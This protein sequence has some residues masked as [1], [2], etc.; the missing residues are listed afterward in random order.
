MTRTIYRKCKF[1]GDVHDV[2]DWPDNHREWVPDNRSE[3]AAPMLANSNLEAL[4]GLDGLQSQVDG[5][6]YTCARRMRAEY[7]A[8]EVQEVG[9][10]PQRKQSHHAKRKPSTAADV[11]PAIERAFSQAGLGA[12]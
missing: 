12:R 5:K 10:E 8:H 9:N 7:R 2:N 6:H 11:K 3:L 4:G 1:C